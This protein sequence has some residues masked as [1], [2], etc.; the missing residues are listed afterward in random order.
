MYPTWP[1]SAAI[2]MPSVAGEANEPPLADVRGK[3]YRIVSSHYPPIALFE[4]LVRPERMGE[5]FELEALTN[6]RLREQAGQL[7]LVRPEDR[8]SEPGGSVVMAAFTHV[9]AGRKSRFSDGNYGVYYA[10]R[11]LDTAIAETR[12]HR[13]RFLRATREE[14]GE[15]DMRVYMGEV[16]QRLHD[17]RGAAYEAEHD[18]D[19]WGAGQRCGRRLRAEG[20]RG[21]VYRSVRNPGG[22]CI[23]ALRPPAVTVPRQSIHLA[24]EWGGER[25]IR[26]FHKRLIH[27]RLR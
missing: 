6:D 19:D 23:G 1:M 27:T 25:I 11:S 10:G 14:P 13:E 21:V 24:Y 2:W 5:V 4:G 16:V 20:S 26:V 18:P 17:L 7:H 12:Y 9:S 3:Q 8:L 22:E 15:I